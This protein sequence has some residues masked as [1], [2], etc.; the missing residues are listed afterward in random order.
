MNHNKLQTFILA[1]LHEAG[2]PV[3]PGMLDKATEVCTAALC[4]TMNEFAHEIKLQNRAAI[5][6]SPVFAA[7]QDA[8]VHGHCRLN[9][10]A[11][12]N[13]FGDHPDFL[14]ILKTTR[15]G[16]E[17]LKLEF[18]DRPAIEADPSCLGNI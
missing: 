8:T 7:G 6:Y 18:F 11:C 13:S 4:K 16:R 5:S 12:W 9:A 10:S 2:I 1:T 3:T 14:G 17:I 15:R